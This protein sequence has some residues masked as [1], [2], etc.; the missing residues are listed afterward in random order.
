MFSYLCVTEFFN[1]NVYGNVIKRKKWNDDDVSFCY[2]F[3]HSELG[4]KK[5]CN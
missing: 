4:K 2:V 3:I 5:C 1:L